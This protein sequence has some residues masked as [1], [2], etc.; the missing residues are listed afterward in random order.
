MRSFKALIF[1][2][3]LSTLALLSVTSCTGSKGTANTLRL[4]MVADAKVL[5]PA[6]VEDYYSAMAVALTNEGLLQYHYLKRPHELIP[7]LAESMPEVSKDGLTY[8]F[9]I[10]KGVKFSDHA[11]FAGG[12]GREVTA[13]DFVYSFLRVADPKVASGGFWIFDGHIKG[14]NEWR[15]KQKTAEKIDYDHPPEG[16]KAVDASTLQITLLQKYPQLLFVLAMPQTFV[17]AHEVVDKLGK[18]FGNSPVGTGPYKF[19][20]WQ[21]GSRIVFDRNPSWRGET[22]PSDGEAADKDAALLSDAG[23]AIPFADRV[24]LHVFVES[25]P[26][27]LN[28]LSGSLDETGIPKDNFATA[29]KADTQE[30][31]PDLLKKGI[32][33]TKTAEPDVTYTAFNLEDPII[34]KGGANLR[35]AI[36]LALD[37]KKDIEV[38]LNGRGIIAQSP[39]PPGLAG[40]DEKYVNPYSEFSIEKA[41]EYLKK[42]GYPE[43]KGLPELVFESTQGTDSRQR[44]EKFQQE[45]AAIGIKVRINVNQFSEL[46]EKINQKKAQMWGIA[47]LADY[48]DAE[49]FLQLLYGANK[50]PG[51]NGSNFDNKEY[52]KLYEQVRGMQDSPE[53]RKL[54]HRMIEVFAEEMPW[55]AESHRISYS[56]T[57]PW[58]KNFK[59]GYMGASFAKF[60]RVD[61]EAKKQA[62]K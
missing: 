55:V 6:L 46:T 31:Q 33:L 37:K 57:H 41:K 28:F 58:L 13:Q 38:F 62:G 60:L 1:T 32:S 39:V 11:A 43:G 44:A 48:P 35:K 34:K 42:A 25:Q 22:Y 23:K 45:L 12:K 5:D 40:Y 61:T 47:W 19:V 53:R 30:L 16:L 7:L 15:E 8:T 24:E 36:S 52:N 56:L 21:R 54:I 14:L 29:I 3:S 50:T 2:V 59:P 27:W 10:K 51:P 26:M 17:V 4:P 18:D 9:K 20:N 49:N